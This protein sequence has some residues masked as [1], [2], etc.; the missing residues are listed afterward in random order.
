MTSGPSN[1]DS[2]PDRGSPRGD[3]I[4]TEGT[5]VRLGEDGIL[6]MVLKDVKS[7]ELEHA[8][9]TIDAY[10]TAGKG[11]RRPVIADIRKVPWSNV[12]VAGKGSREARQY[13]AS[14]EGTRYTSAA[15]VLVNSDLTRMVVN[16]FLRFHDPGFPIRVFTDEHDA[17][18]WLEPYVP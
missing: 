17:A 5:W 16:F 6:R 2:G 10:G 15:A 18:R 12:G 7:F 4:E 13:F 11:A 9:Q 8:R 3:W 1:D 14:P